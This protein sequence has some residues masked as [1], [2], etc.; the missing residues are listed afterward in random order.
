MCATDP[1]ETCWDSCYAARASFRLKICFYFLFHSIFRKLFTP[2]E[3]FPVQEYE[4]LIKFIKSFFSN[5]DVSTMCAMCAT[6]PSETC[7]DSCYSAQFTTNKLIAKGILT[8]CYIILYN[9]YIK[10]YIFLTLK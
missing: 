10:Y 6:D 2:H 5:Q 3:H 4:V 7:W 8:N 1:S 9:L